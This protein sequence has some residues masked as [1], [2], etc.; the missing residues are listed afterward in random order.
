[1]LNGT[2]GLGNR[3]ALPIGEDRAHADGVIGVTTCRFAIPVSVGEVR[4]DHQNEDVR[5]FPLDASRRV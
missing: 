3:I 1:L 4:V 5:F 2:L